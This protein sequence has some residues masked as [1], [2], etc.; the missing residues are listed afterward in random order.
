M[1]AYLTQRAYL[2]L[3]GGAVFEGESFGAS[4][5]GCVPLPL[6]PSHRGREKAIVPSPLRGEG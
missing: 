1:V 4:A 6:A 5:S 3:S 2:V